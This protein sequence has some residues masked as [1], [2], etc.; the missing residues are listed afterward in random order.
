LQTLYSDSFA[1]LELYLP[2]GC[3]ASPV[4]NLSPKTRAR[5]SEFAVSGC[6]LQH[7]TADRGSA[8]GAVVYNQRSAGMQNSSRAWCQSTSGVGFAPVCD[9]W[10]MNARRGIISVGRARVSGRL[11]DGSNP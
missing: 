9:R 8:R 7:Q 4:P 10:I 6:P 1:A 11:A 3:T 5:W 2:C